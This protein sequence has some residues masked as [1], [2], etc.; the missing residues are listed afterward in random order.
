MH[1]LKRSGFRTC[2]ACQPAELALFDRAGL[3][4]SGAFASISRLLMVWLQEAV[5]VTQVLAAASVPSFE[6]SLLPGAAAA[7]AHTQ[8]AGMRGRGTS[9][10]DAF[11]A[12]VLLVRE[13][14]QPG[15]DRSC[16]HVE[17]DTGGSGMDY[18]AGD[19][20]GIFV[21]NS[22][23]A[24]AEAAQLL[25][26]PLDTVFSLRVPDGNSD[27]LS[28]PFTGKHGSVAFLLQQLAELTHA[29]MEGSGVGTFQHSWPNMS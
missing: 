23:A 4:R 10:H 2:A 25:G 6:V 21:E 27:H 3:T 14:H 24:V 28:A 12:S 9:S 8:W 15:S 26:M 22:A 7:A 20:V 11:P 13:L 17:L 1:S 29:R 18:E 16:L 5:G 19:H